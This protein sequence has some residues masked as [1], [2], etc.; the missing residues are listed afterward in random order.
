MILETINVTIENRWNTDFYPS[1][2]FFIASTPDMQDEIMFIN[3]ITNL[4]HCI[5]F[6]S[7]LKPIFD[8]LN[9][10]KQEIE[11]KNENSLS[12]DFALKMLA[13]ALGNEETKRKI[14][15]NGQK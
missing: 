14:L 9:N 1:S 8:N 7:E 5:G 4:P 2:G 15:T 10:A 13:T 3:Q 6:Y 12:E 11:Q